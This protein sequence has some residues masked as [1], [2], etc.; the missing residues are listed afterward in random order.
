MSFHE[1]RIQSFPV[2]QFSTKWYGEAWKNPQFREGIAGSLKV[3]V[4]VMAISTIL[5]FLSAHV[6]CR[7]RPQRPL[8]Y[9]AFV[10][11]P[12]LMPLLLSGMAL[13]MYY[14]RI[15]IAGSIWAIVLAHSCYCAPFAMGLIRNSYEGLNEE[16]E[17]AAVNLGTGRLAVIL[18]V[19]LPQ[20]WPA[21]A[22]AAAVSFLL[23]WDEFVM[24]WFVGG[25]TK[26]L[27][28]VIYSSLGTS[29]DPSVNAVGVVAM[30]VSAFLLLCVFLMMVFFQRGRERA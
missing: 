27:P 14:Q 10:C 2:E 25:F 6:L 20:M 13:L 22:S 16:V 1:G 11:L 30:A 21:V 29:F 4:A 12:C 15:R 23:S 9:I 3:G 8:L 26:T 19:V 7:V 17:Q 5:G 18:R 24:A 28:T